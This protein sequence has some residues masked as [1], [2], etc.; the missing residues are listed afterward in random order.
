M[1]L[2]RP[3]PQYESGLPAQTKGVKFRSA[4][5]TQ[6]RAPKSNKC[7][8]CCPRPKLQFERATLFQRPKTNA[9][10]NTEIEEPA[11]SKL[12]HQKC[13][14]CSKRR[15]SRRKSHRR[16]QNQERELSVAKNFAGPKLHTISPHCCVLRRPT[17]NA[18]GSNV[19]HFVRP[20]SLG[21]LCRCRTSSLLLRC[22]PPTA[23]RQASQACQLF[24]LN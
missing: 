1:V 10:S 11:R 9:A 5:P 12:Q 7:C 3:K 18:K 16:K 21:K 20:G 4:N 6:N 22:S 14:T 19:K 23:T 15:Y 8:F 13:Q 17:C 2:S 24:R